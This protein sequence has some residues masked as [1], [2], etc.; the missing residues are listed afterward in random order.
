MP[1][2][3][4]LDYASFEHNRWHVLDWRE[5]GFD[6]FHHIRRN[7]FV[8]ACRHNLKA[9]VLS[10]YENPTGFCFQFVPKES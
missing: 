7:L 10:S 8:Y 2:V 6:S 5:L 3:A 4:K 1:A 9:R